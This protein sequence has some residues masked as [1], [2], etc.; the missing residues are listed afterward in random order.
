M[1]TE[2]RYFL[3][4]LR[5]EGKVNLY[6]AY[7]ET[8]FSTGQI[9]RFVRKYVR[10]LFI[11]KV[12][13]TIYLTPFGSYFLREFKSTVSR[14]EMYWKWIPQS[15]LCDELEVNIPPNDMYI[16]KEMAKRDISK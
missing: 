3:N 16:Y 2:E 5:V 15:M 11:I 10:K 13:N 12:R 8:S 9:A 14:E 1:Y 7:L 4:R 6:Q